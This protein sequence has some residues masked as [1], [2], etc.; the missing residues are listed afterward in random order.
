M[1]Y[2]I[3]ELI[4]KLEFAKEKQKDLIKKECFKS[5]LLLWEHRAYWPNNGSPFYKLENVFKTIEG[6]SPE[7]GYSFYYTSSDG[8]TDKYGDTETQTYLKLIANIDRAARTIIDEF[9]T[10]AIESVT[11]ESVITWLNSIR[12]IMPS[13]EYNI[14]V[15]HMADTEKVEISKRSSSSLKNEKTVKLEKRIEYLKTFEAISKEVRLSLEEQ[16]KN[17]Q[18]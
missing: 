3:A 12:G 6:L 10:L 14:V 5:I 8:N 17:I 9:I 2:Y 15:K 18:K 11:D 7:N 16:V 1:A 13:P 4:T